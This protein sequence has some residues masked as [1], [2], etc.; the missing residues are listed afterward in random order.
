MPRKWSKE[1]VVA[2]IL[3]LRRGE[4]RLNSGYIQLHCIPLYQAA[5]VYF[6]SWRKAIEAA[7]L[8]YDDVRVLQRV[9]PVWSQKKIIA[10]IR[11]RHRLKQPLNSNHIQTKEQ[12]LYGAALK[13]FG[14]W[15]QAVAAAGLNYSKLRKKAPMRSWSK[16][17]IVAEVIR[18]VE[19]GLSIRGYDVHCE[20]DGLY[21]AAK[22]HF[23]NGGWA[24]AR[25]LAGFDPIDPRPWVIWNEQ[26]VRDEILQLH[27][28]GV[29][30]NVGALQ[31]SKY[32][33]IYGAGRAVFGS[34]S[35]AVRAAGLNYSKIRKG[36]QQGWWTK[37]RIIM[38]IRNLDKRGVRLSHNA[39]RNSR[40]ALLSAAA[41]HFGSWSQ[42]VEA[43]GI[44][45]RQ[46]CRV[47]S[48]KAWLR[49]MREDEYHA[50]LER[51]QTHARKRGRLK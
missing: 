10:I 4:Q 21:N 17:A 18:R 46:H 7:G 16:A 2:T 50:T 31:E 29:A 36:R 44:S 45:Y 1:I 24:R 25:V 19:Q 51:A 43:A 9:R 33:Y 48:T 34:W 37:P 6:G 47:W 8:K 13:Y 35:K 15:A 28:S 26:S 49:R 39:V 22:R 3:D 32:R 12:R 14:G 23:G 30:L 5:L 38:C 40:G 42:A 11:R 20:D 27:E 41:F